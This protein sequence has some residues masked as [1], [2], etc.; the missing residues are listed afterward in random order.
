MRKSRPSDGPQPPPRGGALRARRSPPWKAL[1]SG[2]ALACDLEGEK[3]GGDGRVSWDLADQRLRKG[4]K[5]WPLLLEKRRGSEWLEEPGEAVWL[6][7]RPGLGFLSWFSENPGGREP[8]PAQSVP[9]RYLFKVTPLSATSSLPPRPWDS[10]LR[11]SPLP[12][13]LVLSPNA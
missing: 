5:L 6:C 2:E 4:W 13:F 11:A 12:T 9:S 7:R 8:W 3:Y 1:K 10:I